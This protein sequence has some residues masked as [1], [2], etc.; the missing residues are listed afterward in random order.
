[1]SMLVFMNSFSNSA[2]DKAE[3]SIAN[4]DSSIHNTIETLIV[5]TVDRMSLDGH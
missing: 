2:S 3:A 5:V 4:K 1:M